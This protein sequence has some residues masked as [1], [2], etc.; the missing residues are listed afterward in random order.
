MLKMSATQIARE[1]AVSRDME[2]AYLSAGQESH[3]EFWRK[4]RLSLGDKLKAARLEKAAA[5]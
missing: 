1:L 4:R 5:N 3:A 2:T